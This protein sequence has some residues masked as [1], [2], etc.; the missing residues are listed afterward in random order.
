LLA[1]YNLLLKLVDGL[2]T[3]RDLLLKILIVGG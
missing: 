1:F 2:L 3:L